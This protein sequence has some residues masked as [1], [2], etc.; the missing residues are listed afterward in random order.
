M[1]DG[2]AG[3]FPPRYVGTDCPETVHLYV[4]PPLVEAADVLG[5]PAYADAARRCLEFYVK[6]P[7]FARTETLTHFLGYELEALIDLGRQELA[8]PVLDRLRETQ[9]PGGSVRGKGGAGWVCIPGLAQLAV[10]WYKL[11]QWE[12]ADKALAWV[13]ACQRPSGGFRGSRGLGASYKRSVEVSWAAKF[14]LDAHRLRIRAFFD[15]HETLLP[16]HVSPSDGRSQLLLSRIKSGDTVLEVGCGKGRFLKVVQAA[17]PD[18]RCTGVEPASRLAASLPP[19]IPAIAGTLESVPLPADSFDVVFSVEAIEHCTNPE[20]AVAELV[21]VTKPGGWVIIIDKQQPHWGRL[22]C[23]PWEHWPD[24]RRLAALVRRGCDQVSAEPVAYDDRPASDGLMVAW[25]G[26]KRS[27]LSGAQW[28]DALI[29]PDVEQRLVDDVRFNRL[30]AWARAVMLETAP[31]EKVLEIGS[32]TGQISLHLAQAG[33]LVTCLDISRENLDFTQRCAEKLGLS[34]TTV[35][36]DAAVRIPFADDEFDCVWSSGLLEH[37]FADQ[38][39]AMLR[40]WARVCRGKLIHLVPNASSLAYRAGKMLH[41]RSGDWPYGL[42]IPLTSLADDYEAAGLRV[43]A[44][45]SVGPEH[46]LNFLPAEA[47]RLRQ[48]LADLMAR[49]PAAERPGWNQGYLLVTVGT[50]T[51]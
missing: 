3:G 6:H 19:E 16:S 8:Q 9:K 5:V 47:R 38:R 4:L 43:I 37:F 18:V 22:E 13:E 44:E 32:G 28:T 33:R 10:C 20:L 17:R 25:Q 36:E 27:R 15:R 34:I 11:G 12:P 49:V 14:Y 35:C 23:P 2:G 42:E 7:D 48:G 21:R 26:R 29:S 31:G 51:R 1:L 39:R 41:E 50:K 46:A 30:S 24:V 45:F 40:S